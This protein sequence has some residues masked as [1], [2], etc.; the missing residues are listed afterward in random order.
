MTVRYVVNENGDRVAILLDIEEY[1][2]IAAQRHTNADVLDDD[3]EEDFDP[4][5]SERRITEF[6]TS[7]EELLGPPVAELADEVAEVM[8][9]AWRDIERLMSGKPHNKVLATQLLLGQRAR[10]SQK[11]DDPDQWRLSAA[12]TLLS[13]RV[14]SSLN[15]RG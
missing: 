7:A 14:I 1:E 13:G 8:R 4:E 5:E 10:G 2:R 3:D 11:A 9:A 6:I 15:Q 12:T